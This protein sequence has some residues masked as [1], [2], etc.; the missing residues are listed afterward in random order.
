[1]RAQQGYYTGLVVRTHLGMRCLHKVRSA[2]TSVSEAGAAVRFF[3]TALQVSCASS[4][5]KHHPRTP[6]D[7][8]LYH[9]TDQFH[10]EA[11]YKNQSEQRLGF[12]VVKGSAPL[13]N[14]LNDCSS[15]NL[16]EFSVA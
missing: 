16:T 3:R 10:T 4:D 9:S 7:T 12:K 6:C 15:M 1:M 14:S 11:L 2:S 8:G 13:K 5:R